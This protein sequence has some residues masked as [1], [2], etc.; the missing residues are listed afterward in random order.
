MWRLCKEGKLRAL[1]VIGTM[2]RRREA[3]AAAEMNFRIAS[4][5]PAY[6]LIVMCRSLN[7][8]D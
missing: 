4:A 7:I 1:P 5:A 6:S 3:G 2:S 8:E